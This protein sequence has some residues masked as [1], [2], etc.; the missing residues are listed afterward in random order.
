LQKSRIVEVPQKLSV[1][2]SE[3][4]DHPICDDAAERKGWENFTGGE[5]ESSAPV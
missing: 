3:R 2:F 4:R 1:V 5:A